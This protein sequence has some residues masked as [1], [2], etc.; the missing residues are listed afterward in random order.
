MIDI[1]KSTDFGIVADSKIWRQSG[2][3]PENI[4]LNANDSTAAVH[5]IAIPE[6]A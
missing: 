3:Q 4:I 6:K 1:S 5:G 2:M